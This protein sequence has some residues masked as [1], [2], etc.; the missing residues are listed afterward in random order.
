ML[1]TSMDHDDLDVHG[2]PG[3]LS[4]HQGHPQADVSFDAMV[5]NHPSQ[6]MIPGQHSVVV[7]AGLP[8]GDSMMKSPMK[9]DSL[10]GGG[11]G[12]SSLMTMNNQPPQLQQ[13]TKLNMIPSTSHNPIWSGFFWSVEKDKHG[14]RTAQCKFCNLI[15]GGRP[16]RLK[17]HFLYPSERCPNASDEFIEYYK[18]LVK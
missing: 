3:Q 17:R 1:N 8:A 9:R 12:G 6:Q 11:G 16:M 15:M 10:G 13:G 18:S 5:G 2:I 4:M 7:G 14:R